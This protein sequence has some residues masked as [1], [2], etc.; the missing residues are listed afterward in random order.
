MQ[1]PAD[2]TLTKVAE[3]AAALPSAVSGGSGTF[4]VDASALTAYD[5]ATIALLMQARRAAQAAGRGFS[6]SGAPQQL[7]QLAA[8][9][10]V[11]ELLA[12]SPSAAS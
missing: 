9:Y 2:A 1:L 7:Q 11:E 8:L 12:L 6:V 3:L 4:T 10:G 5:T